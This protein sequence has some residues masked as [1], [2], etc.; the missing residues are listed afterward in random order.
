MRR[1]GFLAV[2]ASLALAAPLRAEPPEGA[3]L[4]AS[5][6]EAAG[7]SQWSAVNR[8]RFAWRH[9]PSGAQRAYDWDVRAGTVTARIA[10]GSV[11]FPASG[12]KLSVEAEA[13]HK[14]YVNDGY[15]L[16]FPLHLAWDSGVA[17]EDL[18]ARTVPGLPDLGERRALAVQYGGAGGYTPGDRYVLYLGDDLFPVAWAY[19]PGG[20]P[21]PKLVARWTGRRTL[22]GVAVATRFETPDGAPFVTIPEVAI[23]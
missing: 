19:H 21:E 17:F 6:A 16:L 5:V 20:A 15:W 3:A 4:A 8:V 9:E 23:E 10:G 2:A 14:A 11:S 18:G 12:G 22:A 13:A 1:S 7:A